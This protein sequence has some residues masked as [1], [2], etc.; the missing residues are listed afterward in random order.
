M[1]ALARVYIGIG[2]NIGDREAHIH[3][4]LALLRAHPALSVTRQS[5]LYNTEPVGLL[6]QP[7]F[8]N[9]V[10]EVQ[11][12]LSPFEVLATLHRVESQLGRIRTIRNGPR[13][14][15]LDLLL[16]NDLVLEQPDLI[17]PHPRLA[18]RA[19]VLVPLAELAPH[20]IHPVSGRSIAA[21][22]AHLGPVD[23]L[24]H[25]YAQTHT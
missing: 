22:L 6:E 7:A 5:S 21:L 14:I 1:V 13:V 4:A 18:E 19:F 12:S 2:G 8:L 20:V 3:R 9:G 25:P 16:Y 11:T 10:V 23:H 24:V 15:D 17:L